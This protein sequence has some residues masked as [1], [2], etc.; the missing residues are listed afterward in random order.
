MVQEITTK[1]WSKRL[2][3]AFFGVIIG[4]A[5]IAGS[6]Y[7]TFWNE[8]H[9]LHTAQSL[10][11]ANQILIP[12]ASAPIDTN[13]NM[14]LIYVTGLA[15]TDDI[16]HDN[17]LNVS[18]KAIQLNR[19]VE[20]YQWEENKSTSTKSQVGGSEQTVTTYTYKKVWSPTLI[21]SSTFKESGHDNP[22]IMPLASNIEYANTV[23]VGDFHLQQDLISRISG[24][25]AVDLRGVDFSAL[26]SQLGKPVNH[27]GTGLYIGNNVSTPVIG[28]M[29]V[30]VLAVLPKSVSIIAQQAGSTLQP[31]MAKAGIAVS[32]IEMGQV[33]SQQMIK[34]AESENRLMT[35]AFRLAALLMMIIGVGLITS[36]IAVLADVIPLVGSLVGFGVWTVAF[37]CGLSLWSVAVAIAWFTFRPLWAIGLLVLTSIICFIIY[38]HK[39]KPLENNPPKQ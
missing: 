2:S 21:N 10:Q 11:E 7:L 34:N 27:E 26:S 36:P 35:W 8:G 37:I 39:S 1:S 5:L 25:I 15:T 13:N 28:D 32:L 33:S 18:I 38:R 22:S 23:T 20:M 17:I 30:S 31:Y 3:N 16:L 14:R 12:V 9:G 29:K 19:H 24:G 6:F 4:I